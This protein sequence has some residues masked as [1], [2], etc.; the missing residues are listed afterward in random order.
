MQPSS[1]AL[2]EEREEASQPATTILDSRAPDIALLRTRRCLLFLGAFSITAIPL[3]LAVV[4]S[5]SG[6]WEVPV[7]IRIVQVLACLAMYAGLHAWPLRGDDLLRLERVTTP[8]MAVL[9]VSPALAAGGLSSIYGISPIFVLVGRTAM[10]ADPWRAAL[11][12]ALLTLASA[13]AVYVVASLFSPKIAAQWMDP[14]AVTSLFVYVMATAS[15]VVITLWTGH[16]THTLQT[17]LF[18]AR[19]IG[20]YKLRRL[21][22]AG[23]MGEVWAA[24]FPALKREVAVKILRLSGDEAIVRFERE[25][26]ATAELTHP[27]TVRVFDYG[28][29]DDGLWYYAMEKLEGE[30]LSALI[31]REGS[32]SPPRARYFLV[33]A[34]RAL[35]EAHTCGIIHRDIKP[36]NL[37]VANQGGERDFL[38]VLDFGIAKMTEPVAGIET[39]GAIQGTPGY[40]APEILRGHRADPRADIYALGACGYA[41]LTGSA[42]FPGATIAALLEATLR[43][44]PQPPSERL[45]RPLPSDLEAVIMRCLSSDPVARFSSAS[46]LVSALAACD[47]VEGW[48][49][50]AAPPATEALDSPAEGRDLAAADTERASSTKLAA[51]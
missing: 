19:Q 9:L 32:L 39:T 25:V 21:L 41:M 45:G 23:G 17:Q 8:G 40:I 51:D 5:E 36:E 1:S 28:R 47:Q 37:F 7:L 12:S 22:G 10:R 33:Q 35:A 27:N 20:R 42:P 24:Y 3:D 18:E 50:A 4:F 14:A 38:K 34:A 49:P 30:S 46:A 15:V 29:T 31:R 48:T 43:G 26:R 11:P 2:V 13:P 6:P 44:E 16:T